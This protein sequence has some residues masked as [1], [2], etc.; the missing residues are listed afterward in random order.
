M[1]RLAN[2]TFNKDPNRLDRLAM[3]MLQ[4]AVGPDS[5]D[6]PELD[7]SGTIKAFE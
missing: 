7:H 1:T 4:E 5:G 6:D 3:R 2:R